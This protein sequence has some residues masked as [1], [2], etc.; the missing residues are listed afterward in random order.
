MTLNL[1]QPDAATGDC[2]NT[3]TDQRDTITLDA[4]GND[5]NRVLCGDLTGQ[6][7]K[8]LIQLNCDVLEINYLNTTF[9]H[10]FQFLAY[11]DVSP[12]QSTAATITIAANTDATAGGT[13]NWRVIFVINH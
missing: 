9:I 3:G 6:H 2:T 1:A 5:P 11:M 7:G 4:G 8:L 12:T 10:N 13:K